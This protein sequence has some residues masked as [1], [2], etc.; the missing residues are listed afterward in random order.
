MRSA[1]VGESP[2]RMN[3]PFALWNRRAVVQLIKVL[4]NVDMPIRTVGE[5]LLRWGY[6]SQRPG[7]GASSR[8]AVRHGA[9]LDEVY[10]SIA[11]RARSEGATICWGNEVAVAGDGH[12]V[13]SGLPASQSR[14]LAAPY[15]RQ[16]L[17]MVSAISNQG[18]VRFEFIE[19]AMSAAPWVSFMEK[20][21]ADNQRKVF[22][23]VDDRQVCHAS[24]VTAWLHGHQDTIELFC[25]PSWSLQTGTPMQDAPR[26]RGCVSP[27]QLV[28]GAFQ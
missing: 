28:P 1:I 13:S 22:L 18:L 8:G 16:G 4:F 11:A 6:V 24:A 23:I 21:V 26:S 9:W 25:C 15:S 14:V 3:L 20:L 19:G 27:F 5:Y 10:P 12:W 17:A 7:S 2:R